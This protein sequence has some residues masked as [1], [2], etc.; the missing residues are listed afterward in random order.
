[1][2]RTGQGAFRFLPPAGEDSTKV[3]RTVNDTRPQSPHPPSAPDAL[4]L[5]REAGRLLNYWK[6]HGAAGFDISHEHLDRIA[7][8]GTT[9][10]AAGGEEPPPDTLEQIRADLGDCKRCRL[11]EG[12]RHIVFGDGSPR[13]RLVFVGEGPGADED[14]R[15][16]PFVG[17]AGQL[18]DKII[19][20]MQMEREAVYICNIIKCR[21]PKN[22]NPL[23]DEVDCCLPFLERQLLSIKPDYIC[24]L[25][26]IAAHSLLGTSTAISRLR[27]RFHEW[28]GIPVMPTYHPAYLL[29]NPEQKRDVWN[30]MQMLMDKMGII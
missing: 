16:M 8:W 20:A 25:G 26:K 10:A 14:R 1:M 29:R 7:R 19:A 27:G 24:T 28:K 6:R 30:D 22:R 13:A 4:T 11:W 17:A 21:P 2:I 23:P 15:G 9:P 5:V 3:K 18:L 12:R